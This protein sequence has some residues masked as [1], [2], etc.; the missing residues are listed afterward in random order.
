MLIHN[1]YDN[2]QNCFTST[3]VEAEKF[4]LYQ[5]KISFL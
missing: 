3:T 5:V 1:G 2:K 4:I